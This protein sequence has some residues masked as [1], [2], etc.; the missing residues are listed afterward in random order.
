MAEFGEF[1]RAIPPPKLL[2]GPVT[3]VHIAS[4][5][6]A[7]WLFEVTKWQSRFC[8]TR[9]FESEGSRFR[10]RTCCALRPRD[11]FR[12]AFVLGLDPQVRLR[13]PSLRLTNGVKPGGRPVLQLLRP[14]HDATE[15]VDSARLAE[16]PLFS[17]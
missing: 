5:W 13:G 7:L 11:C 9:I 6:R 14:W 17:N 16:V 1:F 15:E 8:D 2:V 10:E 4:C 3:T 12:A